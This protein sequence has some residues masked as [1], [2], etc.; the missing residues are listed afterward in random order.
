[1]NNER[2]LL[3]PRQRVGDCFLLGHCRALLP[4]RLPRR[5]VHPHLRLGNQPVHLPFDDG[6]AGSN[7]DALRVTLSGGGVISLVE[8]GK[9]EVI[10][11]GSDVEPI[12]EFAI[13][14]QARGEATRD[15]YREV[16]ATWLIARA[17][18][19]AP[20]VPLSA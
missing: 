14:R 5:C 15:G 11:A 9:A 3:S 7:D 17:A 6:Q 16:I 13:D 4:R 2:T 12:A 20:S 1:M 8:C 10:Q 18:R 19:I